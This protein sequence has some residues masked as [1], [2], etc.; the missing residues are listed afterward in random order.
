MAVPQNAPD[1]YRWPYQDIADAAHWWRDQRW[2]RSLADLVDYF[3]L[4]RGISG[5][6]LAHRLGQET[7]GFVSRIRRGRVPITHRMLQAISRALDLSALEEQLLYAVAGEFSVVPIPPRRLGA[8]VA[9]LRDRESLTQADLARALGVDTS[10]VSRL[11]QGAKQ[12]QEAELRQL[13]EIL[14][15]ARENPLVYFAAGRLPPEA[16]RKADEVALAEFAEYVYW[17]RI[18]QESYLEARE[19]IEANLPLINRLPVNPLV[20]EHYTVEIMNSYADCLLMTGEMERGLPVTQKALRGALNQSNPVQVAEAQTL[21]ASIAYAMDRDRDAIKAAEY[22]IELMQ[23]LTHRQRRGGFAW[24][25][26]QLQLKRTVSTVYVAHG[27]GRL[28]SRYVTEVDPWLERKMELPDYA[29]D[30]YGRQA[31]LRALLGDVDGALRAW[32][33]QQR[34]AAMHGTPDIVLFALMNGAEIALLAHELS[35]AERLVAEAKS[36]AE[37]H[38]LGYARSNI[39]RVER[40]VMGERA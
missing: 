1:D 39:E 15:D 16:I 17:L 30:A 37:K 31:E 32:E 29:A 21:A 5:V 23:S 4:A 26:E 25:Y 12:A 10:T 40:R 18:S 7:S 3:C 2:R 38:G 33:A 22:G 36:Q 34:A 19:L 6:E 13:S 11:E 14:P 24:S 20:R 35:E 28:D 27:A 9:T 8:L